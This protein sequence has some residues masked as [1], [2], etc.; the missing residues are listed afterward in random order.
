VTITPIDPQPD[1]YAIGARVDGPSRWLFV[2]GQVPEDA[3]G[4]PAG[5]ADQ[6]RLW[7]LEIEA[8]AAA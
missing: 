4:V 2:S 7:L 3:A 5:F 6:A 8:V 1:A